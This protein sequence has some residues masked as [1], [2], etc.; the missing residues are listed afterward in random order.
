MG[1]SEMKEIIEKLEKLADNANDAILAA[2]NPQ[3]Y[4]GYEDGVLKAVEVIKEVF[5][6]N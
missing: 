1:S 5:G 6:L 2:D 4:D 3:Y